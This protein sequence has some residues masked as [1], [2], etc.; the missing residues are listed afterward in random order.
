LESRIDELQIEINKLQTEIDKLGTNIDF[1]S[2][3]SDLEDAMNEYINKLNQSE[4]RWPH[5]R[6]NFNINDRSFQFHVGDR[7]WNSI[8]ATHKAL[9]LFAYHYGLLKLSD[10][11]K[12][13]F[14]GLLIIDFPID[15]TERKKKDK[16]VDTENYLVKPFL[17]LTESLETK[18]QVIFSGTSFYLEDTN[19][20]KLD[21]VWVDKN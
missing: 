7:K 12:Y 6:I 18:P 11:P 3:A 1:N 2:I 10:I 13:N 5:S 21:Q 17:E 4:I 15:L 19:I 20:L 16:I 8:S 9:F 14:P